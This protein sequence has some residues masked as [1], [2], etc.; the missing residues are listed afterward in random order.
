MSRVSSKRISPGGQLGRMK[1][2]T[3]NAGIGSFSSAAEAGGPLYIR[4]TRR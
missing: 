3:S 4:K 1:G 2:A